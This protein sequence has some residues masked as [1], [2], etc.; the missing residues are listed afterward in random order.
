MS[1]R[2]RSKTPADVLAI[3]EKAASLFA[4]E[5]A[6]AALALVEERLATGEHVRLLR[7]KARLLVF[8]DREAEAGEILQRI[9]PNAWHPGFWE[10]AQSGLPNSYALLSKNHNVAYFPVRKCSSTS[11]HNVMALLDGGVPK[12]EDIHGSV[13]SY[14]MIDRRAQRQRL[15]DYMSVLIVR[16][17]ID[18]VRSY[19]EGNIAGREHL[20][21]DTGGKDSFYGLSTRPSYEEFLENFQAYRRTFITVRNHTDPLTGY[22][23]ADASVFDWIGN[24]SQTNELTDILS[25]RSSLKLPKLQDMRRGKGTEISTRAQDAEQALLPCYQADY[26][27]FGRWF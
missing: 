23:G 13:A 10:L 5:H 24:T 27:A 20:E 6:E 19:F 4:S 16:S 21:L 22:V 15:A 12:G 2:K 11:L 3:A 26:D 8:F 17:P 18:R 14:E 7:L 9:L 25:Q 1:M